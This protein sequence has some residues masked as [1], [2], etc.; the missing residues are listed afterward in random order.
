MVGLNTRENPRRSWSFD[1]YINLT[2][3][4]K[5]EKVVKCILQETG[6]LTDVTSWVARHGHIHVLG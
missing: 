5:K 3:N 4:G 1:S 6:N 2:S